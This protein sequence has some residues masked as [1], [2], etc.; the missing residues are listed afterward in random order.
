MRRGELSIQVESFCLTE[1]FDIINKSSASFERKGVRLIVEPTNDIVKADKALTLFMIN[2]LSDNARKFTA[3][4]GQVEIYSESFRDYVEI[5]VRDTGRGMS[6]EEVAHLF[7]KKAII[8]EKD[9]STSS[10][11]ESHGFGLLN[12]K[13]I[14]EKYKKTSNLFQCCDLFVK[15]EENKGTTFSFR[16]PIG[17]LMSIALFLMTALSI[18]AKSSLDL[19]LENATAY[20]DSLYTSNINSDFSASLVFADSCI[21]ELNH[22][23]SI[24]YPKGNNFLTIFD[25]ESNNFPEIIWY[26][27]GVNIDYGIILSLRNE[28]AV[29]AL[30]LHD[31]A[32]YDYNNKT[33]TQL[34]RELS[35]DNSISTYAKEIE[36]S[37]ADKKVAAVILSLLIL[38]IILVFYFS[39]YQKHLRYQK[40]A[41]R[42]NQI[43]KIL[44]SSLTTEEKLSKISAIWPKNERQIQNINSKVYVDLISSVD[45]IE[46]LLEDTLAIEKEMQ[47]R[48]ENDTDEIN[49]LSFENDRLHV[50][51]N[52]L[53]NCLSTLKHETMYYPAR[54]HR[55]LDE[56][57]KDIKSIADMAVYYR[58]VFT[59]LSMQASR[60]I[61]IALRPDNDS[62]NYL[63]FLLKKI[64]QDKDISWRVVSKDGVHISYMI[65]LDKINLTPVQLQNIFTPETVDFRFLTCRQLVREIGEWTGLRMCGIDVS[66]ADSLVQS[67]LCLK[68]TLPRNSADCLN[69]ES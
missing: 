2:T 14:I 52:I 23:Y 37:S 43:N 49:L 61:G 66:Q 46:T 39:Y 22:A 15:S 32:L 69:I 28:A 34:F 53:D 21:E 65:V 7:D 38:L 45:S 26:R 59:L 27:N 60:Q 20:A 57:I 4:G 40:L 6:A 10:N 56:D 30:A 55:L 63:A 5:F 12:C 68:L 51:N 41:E 1:L 17:R 13:G 36:R 67:G 8:D 24:T 11:T 44:L 29:A 16:L 64:N 58:E 62:Y 9:V 31:W 3:E 35:A 33:Y 48:V 47:D 50:V 54:L 25:E 19:H 42:L 18:P